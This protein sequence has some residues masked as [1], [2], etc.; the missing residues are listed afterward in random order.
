MPDPNQVQRHSV[1]TKLDVAKAKLTLSDVGVAV[2]YLIPGEVIADRYQ[3]EG[4]IGEGGFGVVYKAQHSELGFDVAIKTLRRNLVEYDEAEQR[5]RREA[6]LA[7]HLTHPHTIRIYDF[8]ETSHGILFICMEFLNGITLEEKIDTDTHLPLDKVILLAIQI[9]K[10][11][12]EAHQN[13]IIHRDLKPSNIFLCKTADQEDFVK[14]LDF[15]IAKVTRPWDELGY[16][17]KLTRTGTSFGSP[18]YMSPEQVRGLPIS[19][20]ADIYA[21]GLILLEAILGAQIV[22]GNS[23]FDV[24]VKQASPSPIEIPPWIAQSPLGP[25]LARCVAKNRDHRYPSASELLDDLEAISLE[26]A[27]AYYQRLVD[28]DELPKLIATGPRDPMLTDP[29]IHPATAQRPALPAAPRRGNWWRLAIVVIALLALA[30]L[31]RVYRSQPPATESGQAPGH[32]APADATTTN[33]D[34]AHEVGEEPPA[35]LDPIETPPPAPATQLSPQ[36]AATLDQSLHGANHG[37]SAGAMRL[38]RVSLTFHAEPRAQVFV[39]GS[40]RPLGRTPLTL[41]RVKGTRR[42]TYRIEARDHHVEFRTLTHDRNY[43]A[44]LVLRRRTSAITVP[45]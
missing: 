24:A 5:F 45:D 23:P 3:I 2:D 33:M 7:R 39:V 13:G 17:D 27:C 25:V 38:Q 19:P 41:H 43:E 37:F 30:I 31:I 15:G 35:Q 21:F 26:E 9:A 10:S 1:E 18:A 40:D 16:S 8:G 28:N 36:L 32:L 6:L 42:I 34:S 22:D 12:T 20:A 4:I 29:A 11:L 14:V 44:S